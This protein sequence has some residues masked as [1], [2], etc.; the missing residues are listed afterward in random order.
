MKRLCLPAIL[1]AATVLAA[2]AVTRD[3]GAHRARTAHEPSGSPRYVRILSMA[4]CI[5]ETLFAL[6]LGDRVAGVTRFCRYPPGA[7]EKR[8]VGGFLDPNY[9]AIAALEPDLALILPEQE[10]VRRFLAELGIRF[11]VVD[12]K[13]VSDILETIRTVGFLCGVET[14][15]D[16]LVSCIRARIDAVRKRAAG[17]GSPHVLVSIGRSPGS[18]MLGGIY[19]AGR[20]TFYDELL[21]YAG[22]RNAYDGIDI[23]YPVLSSEG[24][25]DLDPD[26]II[27]LA[28][29]PAQE[30]ELLKDWRS[31][32]ELRA[33]KNGRVHVLSGG[34]LFIPGP[35]FVLI[36]EDFARVIHPGE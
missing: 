6:G 11:V 14:R 15:A 18:G 1:V 24:L 2:L 27:E 3:P 33:V 23:A 19:V 12:D 4:P 22:A 9:E 36:L 35:R 32:P 31:L 17:G 16:S 28:H 7:A 29:D 21:T 10:N 8:N 26:V 30:R 13:T 34:H 5:T 20:N 25:L